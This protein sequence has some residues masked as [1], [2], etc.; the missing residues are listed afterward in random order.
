MKRQELP[1]AIRRVIHQGKGLQSTVYEVDF[2]GTRAA[3][4]DFSATRG[5][6]K[7]LVAPWLI[8]REVKALRRLEGTPG[9]P[10]LLGRVD[11]Y[12][13]ALEYVEGTPLDRYAKGELEPWVFPKVQQAVDAIHARGVSHGDLKRRSNLLLTPQGEIYLIDFAAATVGRRRFNPLVNWFQ[14]E[15]AK[16]DDKSMPRLKK[17]VA[18]ELLTPEDLDKLNNPTGL[19]KL[20]RRLLNR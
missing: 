4:K 19:E 13:F 6:F 2:H 10:R 16:V 1:G 17:F 20:A 3:V 11:R 14:R 15:M 9:V 18:P 5:L 7:L 8:G 12:A